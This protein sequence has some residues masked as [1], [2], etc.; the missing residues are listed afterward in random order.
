MGRR[1]NVIIP[2]EKGG[3]ELY[4]MK[5]WLRR[6][7]SQLEGIDIAHRT[8]HQLRDALKR[9]GWT[10]EE[11]DAEV[12]LM[13]PGVGSLVETLVSSVLGEDGLVGEEQAE[14][15]FA[16]EYQL[17]DFLAQNLSSIPVKGKTLKLFVD[18][19]GR[20]G[21][22]YPT[23]VGQIDI[24]ATDEAGAF[25]VFELKRGRSPD[26]AIGQL[27]RYMGWL[28]QTIGKGKD[29]QGIIVAKS[30]SAN[31]KWAIAAVPYVSLFEYEVS[32]QLKPAE[33]LN[34]GS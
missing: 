19:E 14:T 24:L 12:R 22:E 32:F 11:N 8:S 20:E 16:L 30:I 25:F 26:N 23:D 9:K 21:I 13:M 3:V 28:K 5:D 29:V 4:Q 10:V 6:N 18:N 27:A 2:N 17:R 34:G 7:P 33:V 31:L 1:F 15:T